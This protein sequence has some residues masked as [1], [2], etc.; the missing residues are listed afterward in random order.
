[1]NLKESALAIETKIAIYRRFIRR[2]RSTAVAMATLVIVA[3]LA[4]LLAPCA[5][6]FSHGSPSLLLLSLGAWIVAVISTMSMIRAMNRIMTANSH[7]VVLECDRDMLELFRLL[8]ADSFPLPN[9]L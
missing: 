3:V 5:Q 2:Q 8:D 9:D 6:G 1:M 4:C 7:I